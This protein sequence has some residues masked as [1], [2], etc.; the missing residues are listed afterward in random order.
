[1]YI[2]KLTA[3]AL[4]TAKALLAKIQ[5][6]LIQPSAISLVKVTTA[7]RGGGEITIHKF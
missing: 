3:W 2:A 4:L 6:Y 5:I 7:G 1:M